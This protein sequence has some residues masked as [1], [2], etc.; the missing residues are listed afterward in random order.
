MT[1]TETVALTEYVQ[2]CCPQQQIGEYTPD[3]WH[4]IL[5]DLRLEDW[6]AAVVAIKKRSVFV[7]PSEIIAEVREIRNE[8][9]RAAGGIPAPPPE[10]IDHPRAYS[11][12]LQAAAIALGDGRDPDEAVQAMR[13]IARQA[14]R[15]ELEAS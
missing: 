10:L 3:A 4:D 8:R 15:L 1:P 7:D 6:S 2:A 11:A 12:A 5:G 13:A 9:I 14:V